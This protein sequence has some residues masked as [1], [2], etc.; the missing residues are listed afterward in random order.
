MSK[1][2]AEERAYQDGRRET[3]ARLLSHFASEL[4]TTRPNMLTC[5][6][7]KRCAVLEAE[8]L[9]TITALREFC[10]ELGY[11]DWPDSLYLRDVVAKHLARTQRQRFSDRL[12]ELANDAFEKLPP[13]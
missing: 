10:A 9:D 6:P 11:N 13:K 4:Y 1:T 8:R 7:E 2:T 5:S 12:R 3:F